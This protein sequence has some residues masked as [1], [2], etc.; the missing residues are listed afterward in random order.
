MAGRSRIGSTTTR[1]FLLGRPSSWCRTLAMGLEHAHRHGVVHRDIKPSNVLFGKDGNPRVTDF[2]LAILTDR[3]IDARIT[4][5]HQILGSLLYMAPEQIEGPRD[6]ID[7]PTDIYALGIVMFRLMTGGLPYRNA[8]NDENRYAILQE[9]RGGL[10]VAPS[11]LR[12]DLDGRI[13]ALFRK[14]TEREP[15]QRFVSMNAM[16]DAL[17]ELLGLPPT[18]SSLRIHRIGTPSG[19]EEPPTEVLTPSPTD[20]ILVRIPNGS[21]EM[22][23]RDDYFENEG[24]VRVV[25]LTRDFLMGVFPVTQGQYRRL[26]GNA[27]APYFDGNDAFPMENV[28]WFDAIHFCNALSQVEGLRPYYRIDGVH[29]TCQ[30]GPGYRLPTEAEWEY[31]CRAGCPDRYGFGDDPAMLLQHAWFQDNARDSVQP[32]GHWPANRFGLHDLHGNVWEWCWDWFG[33]YDP[34]AGVDPNGPAWGTTRVLRGGSWYDPAPRLCSS[35]RLWW[36]PNDT[37]MTAWKF[38]F[39][40]ARDPRPAE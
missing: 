16:A 12:P 32:V 39:R 1:I 24:P 28:T 11:S 31:A 19:I 35:A 5:A 25:T 18:V 38:G 8:V 14:A 29:V 34:S 26:M 23:S 22:G 20:L 33:P 7:K 13:D 36:E 15:T 37:E 17:G 3:P 10:S 6:A 2:G 27:A 30:G 9:I 4:D 40:V 21:F